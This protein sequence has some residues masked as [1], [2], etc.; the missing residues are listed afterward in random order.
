MTVHTC[1]AGTRFDT[2]LSAYDQC[3][4]NT[5]ANVTVLAANDDD[6]SCS[7]TDAGASALHFLLDGDR[8]Y[9]YL[10]VEKSVFSIISVFFNSRACFF[11]S[12]LSQSDYLPENS[13]KYLNANF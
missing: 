13:K 6:R 12:L 11:F 7:L 10:G 8:D 2:Y 1:D 5:T 3:P 9:Y 4:T